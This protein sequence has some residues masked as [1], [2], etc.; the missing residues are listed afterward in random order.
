MQTEVLSPSQSVFEEKEFFANFVEKRSWEPGWLAD[1]RI[2]RWNSIEDFRNSSSKNENWRFSPQS[3]FS[4]SKIN[5]V[6]S[7]KD[8]I[9]LSPETSNQT[10]FREFNRVILDSPTALTDI[11]KHHG[12]NLGS[13]LF[14]DLTTALFDS[15]YFL[16]SET[17]TVIPELLHVHHYMPEV[18]KIVFR[19]NFIELSPFSEVTLVEF[20]ENH[21]SS[22]QG[23]F[24]SNLLHA[25]I[26]EGATLNRIIVQDS[27]TNSTIHQ[28]EHFAIGQN[29]KVKNISIHLGSA[30]TRNEIKGELLQPGGEFENFS[31][32]LGHDEQLFDQRT[33]QCH[34][35]PNCRSNLI[36]KNALNDDAKSIFSGMIKVLPS[37]A[38]TNAYQTNRNLLLS[39]QAEADSLPG[40]EILANEVKCSHGATTSRIDEDELFY[41][42]SRGI[43][44]KSAEKLLSLGFLE[45]II[46]KV[47]H[48]ELANKI[49]EKIE[50]RF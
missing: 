5:E 6:S 27:C 26:G 39:N 45:E 14:H 12:P 28:L 24:F 41:L 49:R 11:T 36:T 1:Y 22:P 35:A 32:N 34:N 37:A 46:E 40:L 29:A 3:R 30:Q 23:G 13:F 7:S 2:D 33:M 18:D 42:L 44:K 9:Q 15:G 16:K 31:L 20:I 48:D 10:I 17:K 19:R 21:E 50:S 38:N 47:D 25:E 4:P 43:S 8:L